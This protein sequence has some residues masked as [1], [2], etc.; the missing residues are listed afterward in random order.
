MM[1]SGKKTAA[2]MEP[3]GRPP[4]ASLVTTVAIG[5]GEPVRGWARRKA[6]CQ[7]AGSRGDAVTDAPVSAA[8]A[9]TV[10]P[11]TVVVTSWSAG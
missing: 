2:K 5:S 7:N 4:E 11:P 10:L 3:A 1:A 9:A 6:T 8:A